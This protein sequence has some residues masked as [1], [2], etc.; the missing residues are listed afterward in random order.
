MRLFGGRAVKGGNGTGP[1]ARPP[2]TEGAQSETPPT[3]PG[4]PPRQA[5]AE[6]SQTVRGERSTALVH[7]ARSLQSRITDGLAIGL[8]SL[9]GLGA[10]ALYYVHTVKRGSHALVSAQRA[11]RAQAQA[12]APLPPLG[13]IV[14][15][16][17]AQ[18]T[19]NASPA[20]SLAQRILGPPPALPGPAP[21][22]WDR[23]GT[24]GMTP[25]TP[26]GYP[27]AATS[28]RVRALEEQLGGPV[29]AQSSGSGSSA[30]TGTP[31][32][33]PE[34]TSALA[35]PPWAGTEGPGLRPVSTATPEHESL[36]A[37]LRPTV[38]PAAR[39]SVLPTERF[40]LPKGAF[41]DC[42]LET[43]ID[44]T[45]PGMTTCVTATDTFSADGTVVL[46]ER[47]TTLVGETRGEVQQGQ[48][49]VF[50]LWTE[51]RTP[52]GVVVPLDSP[53]TDSLGRSG[54]AGTVNTHFWERFGA[55]ILVSV[56][57]GGVQAGIQATG[58]GG[59]VIVNPTTSEQVM[60]GV[61]NSTINIPPTIEVPQGTRVEVLVARDVDFR[62]VYRLA[63]AHPVSGKRSSP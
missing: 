27:V 51:A 46:L 38:T 11:A 9:L 30:A 36:S 10:L 6:E 43:A 40:L 32:P 35:G 16:K 22:A 52:S 58:N 31:E 18:A 60:T 5:A 3:E 49:R 53:G 20:P 4:V 59:T 41:I 63:L 39:A 45:L 24:P 61:L 29:F 37:L 57:D 1:S 48:A 14:G 34:S 17:L 33:S 47:G 28:P 15:P 7:R 2:D 19:S 54:L 55:A 12:N 56:I 25:G 23:A 62:S 13:R 26:A 50:V 8:V 42:T 21:A 44:S